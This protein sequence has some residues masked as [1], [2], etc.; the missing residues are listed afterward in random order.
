MREEEGVAGSL[1][2]FSLRRHSKCSAERIF[3]YQL[4][5]S[6]VWTRLRGLKGRSKMLGAASWV[7]GKMFC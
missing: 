3:T 5:C 1:L 6:V 7:S 4:R 2:G